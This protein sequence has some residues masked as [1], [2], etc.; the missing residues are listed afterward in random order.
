MSQAPSSS[1]DDM[2]GRR[3]TQS[4]GTCRG[5]PVVKLIHPRRAFT[6]PPFF[7]SVAHFHLL[8]HLLAHPLRHYATQGV[9][10]SPVIYAVWPVA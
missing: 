5:G 10:L 1:Y 6:W 8:N 7:L 9:S 4:I 2:I 3:P